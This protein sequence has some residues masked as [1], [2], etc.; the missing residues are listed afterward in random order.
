MTVA[1]SGHAWLDHEWSSEIR[2]RKAR[3]GLMVS[4]SPTAAA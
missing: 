1:V 4:T 2:P 3:L